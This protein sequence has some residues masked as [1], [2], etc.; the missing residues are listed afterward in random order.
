MECD[1][2]NVADFTSLIK[3]EAIKEFAERLKENGRE[4]CGKYYG[5]IVR[6]KH[7]DNLVKEV[8]GEIK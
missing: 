6:F 1:F 3:A 4:P 7:I 2:N 8:I 5:K